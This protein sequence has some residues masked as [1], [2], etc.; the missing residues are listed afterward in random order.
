MIWTQMKR[1]Y[2]R[3][4]LLDTVSELERDI[5]KC[6][7]FLLYKRVQKQ[8]INNKTNKEIIGVCK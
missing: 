4:W 7:S 5:A 6:D 1:L 8:A 2:W 3:N